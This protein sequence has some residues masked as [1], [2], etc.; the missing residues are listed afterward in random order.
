[1]TLYS[2]RTLGHNDAVN[3]HVAG[4]PLPC[5]EELVAV[6]RAGSPLFVALDKA[7]CAAYVDGYLLQA[8]RLNALAR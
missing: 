8:A 2:L 6:L 5:A 3:A 7:Q 4:A 1:M